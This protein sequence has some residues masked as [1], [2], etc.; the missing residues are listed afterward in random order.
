MYNGSP[1]RFEWQLLGKQELYIPYNA[2]RI[3]SEGQGYSD[4]LQTKHINP[5]LARYELHRVRVV[6]GTLKPDM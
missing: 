4:I 6:E 1:E 5:D 2:Y 3:N